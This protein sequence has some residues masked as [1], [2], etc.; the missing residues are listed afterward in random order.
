MTVP[1]VGPVAAGSFKVGVDDPDALRDL[2]R[3]ERT[4]PGAEAT[5]VR[6]VHRP[7]RSH[8][9]AGRRNRSRGVMRGDC[10]PPGAGLESLGRCVNR[11]PR[12][13][14]VPRSRNDCDWIQCS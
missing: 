5:A 14:S 9:Q 12:S 7:W 4:W 2:G 10:K 8:Q 6:N 11:L 1:G 13:A 3:L